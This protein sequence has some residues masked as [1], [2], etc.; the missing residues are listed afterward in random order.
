MV[1]QGSG[2]LGPK[3]KKQKKTEDIQS[4]GTW[5]SD[6]VWSYITQDLSATDRV[7]STF[8]SLLSS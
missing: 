5:S 3:K 8:Q 4:H 6:C 1:H 2:V 7:A